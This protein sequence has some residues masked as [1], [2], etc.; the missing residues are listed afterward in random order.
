M[1]FKKF[2]PPEIVIL[3]PLISRFQLIF[4]P[5]FFSIFC[6]LWDYLSTHLVTSENSRHRSLTL[7]E[8]WVQN[9]PPNLTLWAPNLNYW[10]VPR[11]YVSFQRVISIEKPSWTPFPIWAWVCDQLQSAFKWRIL[12]LFEHESAPEGLLY[13]NWTASASQVLKKLWKT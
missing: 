7:W 3:W 1:F 2:L 4:R 13:E 5:W 10:S 9:G 11:N 6:S 8:I 12:E